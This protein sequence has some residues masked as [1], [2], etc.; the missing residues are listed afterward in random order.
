MVKVVS[1]TFVDLCLSCSSLCL[2]GGAAPIPPQCM[3]SRMGVGTCRVLDLGQLTQSASIT[4]SQTLAD[5]LPKKL[6]PPPSHLPK[7][8]PPS[9]SQQPSTSAAP[10][11]ATPSTPLGPRPSFSTSLG[12]ACSPCLVY[13]AD[14]SVVEGILARGRARIRGSVAGRFGMRRR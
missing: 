4:S 12:T 11:I 14:S 10:Y 8:Q 6:L 7:H 13:G 3:N 1:N 5:F 9:L 2:Q